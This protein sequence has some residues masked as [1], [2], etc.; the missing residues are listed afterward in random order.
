MCVCAQAWVYNIMA[1]DE[2]E[3]KF[4]RAKCKLFQLVFTL[5]DPLKGKFIQI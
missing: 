3:F 5:R 2:V 4:K 1:F